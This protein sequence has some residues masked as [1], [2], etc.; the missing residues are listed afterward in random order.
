MNSHKETIINR[1]NSIKD[2]IELMNNSLKMFEDELKLINEKENEQPAKAGFKPVETGEQSN[3][4]ELKEV[5][6]EFS[7]SENV[8]PCPRNIDEVKNNTNEKKKRGR[9]PKKQQEGGNEWAAELNKAEPD[10]K[11]PKHINKTY[12]YYKNAYTNEQREKVKERSRQRYYK[13]KALK[14]DKKEVKRGRGRPRKQ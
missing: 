7:Q 2:S 8:G 3:N 6:K 12:S 4:E 14:E 5:M 13:L 10:K 9:K 11:K 1:I